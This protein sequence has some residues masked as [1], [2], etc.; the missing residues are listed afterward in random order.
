MGGQHAGP[1][2]S[3][4]NR[5]SR[6]DQ[7]ESGYL[8]DTPR[9][10]AQDGRPAG[11]FSRREGDRR[12]FPQKSSAL[13][14]SP[15]E[16]RKGHNEST[17]LNENTN[18]VAQ[19]HQRAG[20]LTDREADRWSFPKKSPTWKSSFNQ[21]EGRGK[22]PR[23]IKKTTSEFAADLRP[24][25]ILSQ[26]K[27][28]PSARPRAS[29]ASRGLLHDMSGLTK[30]AEQT[31]MPAKKQSA[32]PLLIP[33]SSAASEFV[34]GTSAV[35][36][37]LL[38]GNRKLYKMYIYQG[39]T[40]TKQR[41]GD[42]AFFK[43]AHKLGLNVKRVDGD[44]LR[45]LDKMAEGRPHN[46]YILEASQLPRTPAEALDNV[47]N[48]GDAFS[49][50]AAHQSVEEIAVNGTSRKI[51]GSSHRYPFVLLLDNILDPGNLGA[52]IRSAAFFG[53]D[54]VA[55]I[56]H[57]LAPFSS[58]TLKASSGA[59]ERLRYLKVRNDYDFVKR[60]QNNGWKFFAAVAPESKSARR[61]G[62]GAIQL[63]EAGDALTKS[64]CVLMLG[65]EGDG[66]R[67]RLQKAA[68]GMVGIEG[69][70]CLKSSSGLDSLNVSVAAA[71]LMQIF[72]RDS[73][74]SA[75]TRGS[76]AELRNSEDDGQLF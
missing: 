15:S 7:S 72:V 76:M 6:K 37:A 65:G 75:D 18:K 2:Q 29:I 14:T 68:D 9:W 64:P 63:K 54:A 69:A 48:P 40:G 12:S 32:V 41:E 59:A 3:R 47:P 74:T 8:R 53:V 45:L 67:P 23:Y 26:E 24:T 17:Y 50:T 60:S 34:Y 25:G 39:V 38:A 21:D 30:P 1:W 19:G 10:G 22:G 16:D 20:R 42:K 33:R 66:L 46:G 51:S 61:V 73:N 36:A 52:I 70:G 43:L 11:R 58:V 13:G 31:A 28:N 62:L 71:L 49:F 27:D 35:K 55:L 57:S 44:G 4:L 5:D 56:D